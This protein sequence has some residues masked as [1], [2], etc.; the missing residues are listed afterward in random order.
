MLEVER[1]ERGATNLLGGVG[2]AA[3]EVVFDHAVELVHGDGVVGVFVGGVEGAG[4][5]SGLDVSGWLC[6]AWS[7]GIT[8]CRGFVRGFAPSWISHEWSSGSES[9]TSGVPMN[10]RVPRMP[11]VS[12]LPQLLKP[13]SHA[14]SIRSCSWRIDG[15]LPGKCSWPW[16]L[17]S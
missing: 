13:K 6:G 1:G 17:A 12:I 10:F 11:P 2:G 5:A 14:L 9:F 7:V 8:R 4:F 16:A 15:I 3:E